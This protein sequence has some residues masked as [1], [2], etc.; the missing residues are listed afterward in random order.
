MADVNWSVKVSEDTKGHALE[1]INES[2]LSAKDFF[3]QLLLI[4]DLNKPNE[5]IGFESEELYNLSLL[6]SRITKMFLEI[7]T[8]E[9]NSIEGLTSKLTSQNEDINRL[10][11]ALDLATKEKREIEESFAEKLKEL[12]QII[13]RYQRYEIVNRELVKTNSELTDKLGH[14]SEEIERL[15]NKISTMR[16]NHKTEI[17]K[18]EQLKEKELQLLAANKDSEAQKNILKANLDYQAKLEKLTKSKKS[19]G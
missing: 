4:W 17:T 7:L 8:R 11:S 9:N 6:T 18:L 3:R 12:S 16:E 19:S 5:P 14:S 1:L 2:G 13:I 15:K 10:E